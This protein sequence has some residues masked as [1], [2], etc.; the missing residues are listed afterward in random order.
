V[1]LSVIFA[2]LTAT[3]RLRDNHL[4][5]VSRQVGRG[6][7]LVLMNFHFTGAGHKLQP[8]TLRPRHF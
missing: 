8:E 2:V 6:A 1:A 5:T 4:A 7:T 3:S